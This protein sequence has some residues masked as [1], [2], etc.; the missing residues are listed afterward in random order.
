MNRMSAS[1]TRATISS[2]SGWT[3]SR[4]FRVGRRMSSLSAFLVPLVPEAV[5]AR[6]ET[7]RPDAEVGMLAI[8]ATVYRIGSR[9]AK[10]VR[11]ADAGPLVEH[12]LSR[13]KAQ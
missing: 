3:L 8:V 10:R 5:G 6:R 7:P 11:R 13:Y 4:S 9:E 2:Q 12:D 1:G